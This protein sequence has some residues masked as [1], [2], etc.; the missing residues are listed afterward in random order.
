[1]SRKRAYI[2]IWKPISKVKVRE[3]ASSGGDIFS[4]KTFTK[5][6]VYEAHGVYVKRFSD[7]ETVPC[8]LVKDNEAILRLVDMTKFEVVE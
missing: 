2:Q 4:I 1:M 6:E 3:G 5:G 7:G 8:Y